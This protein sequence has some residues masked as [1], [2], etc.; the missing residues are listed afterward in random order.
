[1]WGFFGLYFLVASQFICDV[2]VQ[3]GLGRYLMRNERTI[4]MP[5]MV[6]A[7]MAIL[8]RSS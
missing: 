3:D 6:P 4:R 7:R 2:F 8:F 1:M 5:N